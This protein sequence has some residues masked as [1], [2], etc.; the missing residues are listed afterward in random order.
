MGMYERRESLIRQLKRVEDEIL[1]IDSLP[2]EPYSD[3]GEPVIFFHKQFHSGTKW[4]SYAALRNADNG[5]W[6]TTG[7]NSPKSYTWEEL[8]DWMFNSGDIKDVFLANEWVK[9]P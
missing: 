7:P 5:K 6:Y 4:F 1:K 3:D 2:K 9:F 8:A